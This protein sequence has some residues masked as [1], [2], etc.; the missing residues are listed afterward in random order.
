MFYRVRKSARLPEPAEELLK[1]GEALDQQRP[2]DRAAK[3]PSHE[4]GARRGQPCDGAVWPSFFLCPELEGA[5]RCQILSSGCSSRHSST[6]RNLRR[7]APYNP[8]LT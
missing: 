6:I 7:T 4:R 5:R 3:G 1:L 2:V 8:V